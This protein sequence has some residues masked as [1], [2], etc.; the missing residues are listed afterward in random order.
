MLGGEY[1]FKLSFTNPDYPD[2]ILKI[3]ESVFNDPKYTILSN[4]G[5]GN[6][7]I[8]FDQP[9]DYRIAPG[10]GWDNPAES[11]I[12]KFSPSY[13]VKVFSGQR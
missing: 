9:G 12:I 13:H 6:Y 11:P 8:R 1:S 5:A 10:V 3:T 7:R 4:D 2:P